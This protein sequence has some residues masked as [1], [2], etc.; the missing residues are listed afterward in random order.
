MLEDG[1]ILLGSMTCAPVA[2]RRKLKAIRH[3][4]AVGKYMFGL[5][6]MTERR[7][8]EEILRI[9]GSYFFDRR[10]GETSYTILDGGGLSGFWRPV[11]SGARQ[12]NQRLGPY[13]QLSEVAVLRSVRQ[14]ME[15]LDYL[16]QALSRLASMH[17]RVGEN[18]AAHTLRG[19]ETRK[20]LLPRLRDRDPWGRS[21][22]RFLVLEKTCPLLASSLVRVYIWCSACCK[23][24]SRSNRGRQLTGN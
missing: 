9:K 1:L 2:V 20:N 14:A 11:W 16:N 12:R 4:E 24:V 15:R 19:E 3:K 7:E 23:G 22:D 8:E 13:V 6:K 10:E 21:W 5:D 18:T 17:R